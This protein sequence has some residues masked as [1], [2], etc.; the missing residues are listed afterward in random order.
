MRNIT[1]LNGKHQE[2]VSGEVDVNVGRNCG[3]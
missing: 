1:S 3:L 2:L